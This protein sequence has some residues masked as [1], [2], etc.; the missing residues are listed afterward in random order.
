MDIAIMSDLPL[1][2]DLNVWSS[3]AGHCSVMANGTQLEVHSWPDYKRLL[4]D[5]L[6]FLDK[7]QNR[8]KVNNWDAP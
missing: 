5:S 2:A 1:V 6:G 4:M 8:E 3:K 7:A